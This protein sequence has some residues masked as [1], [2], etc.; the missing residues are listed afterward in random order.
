MRKL[1]PSFAVP[2][3]TLAMQTAGQMAQ[4]FWFAP[5]VIGE[6][7][8]GIAAGGHRPSERQQREVIDMV[9][10]KQLAGLQVATSLWLATLQAQ[11]QAWLT[12][13]SAGR[14]LP[15]W[16]D[17]ALTATTARQLGRAWSPVSRRVKTNATRFARARAKRYA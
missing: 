7:L 15:D 17:L 10:E 4:I 16:Q 3:A 8:M 14:A 12:A 11:Q 13:W 1:D 9:T 6:R 2:Y 5:L